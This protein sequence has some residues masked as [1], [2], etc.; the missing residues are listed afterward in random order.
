MAGTN[1]TSHKQLRGRRTDSR[2]CVHS[3]TGIPP[4][5]LSLSPRIRMSNQ[6]PR[7]LKSR[8]AFDT[9]SERVSERWRQTPLS[10]SLRSRNETALLGIDRTR[11]W[12]FRGGLVAAAV[13]GQRG[14]PTADGIL[15]FRTKHSTHHHH[16]KDPHFP[17]GLV[18]HR[19]NQ[20]TTSSAMESF[21][22]RLMA[23]SAASGPRSLRSPKTNPPLRPQNLILFG[24]C[25]SDPDLF[26]PPLWPSPFLPPV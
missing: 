15:S 24:I 5:T 3:S 26:S 13:E 2:W 1:T 16:Q 10:L 25:G 19:H 18:L 9:A 8:I 12:E 21:I 14:R 6:S 4:T 17:K 7:K 23:A 22:K 11:G 20:P